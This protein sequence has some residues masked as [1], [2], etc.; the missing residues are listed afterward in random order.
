VRPTQS[1]ALLKIYVDIKDK[2]L[3]LYQ[4]GQLVRRYPILDLR[5]GLT[6]GKFEI[7]EKVYTPVENLG[8]RWLGFD[9]EPLGIHGIALGNKTQPCL[10]IRIENLHL[11]E[12]YA[13][14]PTGT[15]VEL[16]KAPFE[17]AIL[18]VPNQFGRFPATPSAFPV[19]SGPH[20]YIIQRGNTIWKLSRRFKIT[21]ESILAANLLP[22]PKHLEPGQ[23]INIPLSWP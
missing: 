2:D 1:S 11:E 19:V 8:S 5:D 14:V 20:S 6:T 9:K 4:D 15:S 17:S 7:L 23:I 22:T 21:M 13:L 10:G 3:R 16:T 18:A 12:L